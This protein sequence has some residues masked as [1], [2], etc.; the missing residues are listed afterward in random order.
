MSRHGFIETKDK[1]G[2]C[3]FP[4]DTAIVPREFLKSDEY[5]WHHGVPF[6]TLR[7]SWNSL[8]TLVWLLGDGKSDA[9]KAAKAS[10]RE[11]M[12]LMLN[13]ISGCTIA[14]AADQA[15]KINDE[16]DFD[17]I[18]AA[19][20]WPPWDLVDGPKESKRI[21][22]PGEF[23]DKFAAG[24]DDNEKAL[25][26]KL[27]EL[28]DEEQSFISAARL[29]KTLLE[30]ASGKDNEIALAAGT[31]KAKADT[32]KAKLQPV[33]NH[34]V[35][36]PIKFRATVWKCFA[37]KQQPKERRWAKADSTAGHIEVKG[38]TIDVEPDGQL[39]P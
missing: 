13:G 7:D 24:L 14:K 11:V 33:V 37:L 21:D 4:H 36:G 28:Y 30:V 12:E 6:N 16:E 38:K 5:T 9:V 22:D 1:R 23:F 17:E 32:L 34:T 3:P 29:L 18:H 2:K 10:A 19:I 35:K 26:A 27:E 8:I 31:L 39:W 20:S 25:H 15:M